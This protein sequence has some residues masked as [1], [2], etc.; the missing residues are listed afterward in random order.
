MRLVDGWHKILLRAWSVRLIALGF[1]F[2]VLEALLPFID[3]DSLGIPHKAFVWLTMV[4]LIG[5]IWARLTP[6]PKSLPENSDAD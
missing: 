3:E 1:G 5:A 2:Q 6:Q 4:I